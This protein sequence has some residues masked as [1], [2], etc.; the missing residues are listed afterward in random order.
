MLGVDVKVEDDGHKKV[1]QAEEEHGLAHALQRPPQQSAHPADG[2][3]PAQ[4][5][6]ASGCRPEQGEERNRLSGSGPDEPGYPAPAPA[7]CSPSQTRILT[8]ITCSHPVTLADSHSHGHSPWQLT[9]HTASH[10]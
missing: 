2:R 6:R 8:R 1:Q 9:A 3:R 5:A 7:C 10:T 4:W